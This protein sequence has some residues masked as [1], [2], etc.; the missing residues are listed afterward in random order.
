LITGSMACA[1]LLGGAIVAADGATESETYAGLP[2]AA[3]ARTIHI[4]QGFQV[5][6]VAAEPLVADPV[7]IAWDAA[8]RM[9]L[10]EMADYPTGG[11]AGRI[12]RLEDSDGDGFPDRAS[13]F[14]AGL[15]YPTSVLPLRGGILVAAAP[16]IL[17]LEDRDGDGVADERRVVLTGFGLGTTQLRVNGLIWGIDGRVYAANGRS[18]GQ[19]RNPSD[20][21]AAA[22]VISRR[23]LRFDPV[24]FRPEAIAGPSQFGHDFDA[25]GR[26][27]LSWNTIHVR[28][29]VLSPA[30]LERNP[31]LTRTETVAAISDH[32]DSARVYPLAPPPRTYN[33]EPTD[34]FN[35][36]C[37]LTV[38]CGG[39]FPTP[40]AG[41][42][43]VCEPLTG[44]VHRDELVAGDGPQRVARRGEH[45]REFLASTDPWFH[46]VFARSGPD[47]CLYVA[48]FYRE[49]VEHPEYV[50]REIRASVDYRRGSSHGRI[51]RV[52]PEGA[53]RQAVEDLSRLSSESLVDRLASPNG[54]VR[55]T[56]Q[57]LLLE[58]G[59]ASC[60]AR[61]EASAGGS[62]GTLARVE[63]LWTLHRL[64]RLRPELLDAALDPALDTVP[65]AGERVV[66]N[67]LRIAR[68]LPAEV[69]S[70][71]LFVARVE[72]LAGSPDAEVVRDAVLLLGDLR[73]DAA[74]GA[75]RALAS[76]AARTAP[77][78]ARKPAGDAW[79]LAAVLSGSSGRETALVREL[80]ALPS[81]GSP[82]GEACSAAAEA[83]RAAAELAGADRASA[84]TAEAEVLR[85]IVEILSRGDAAGAVTVGEGLATGLARS[86][87]AP[88]GVAE[89]NRLYEEAVRAATDARAQIGLR[90][91]SL[92]LLG[93]APWDSAQSAVQSALRPGE[94]LEL[95]LEAA[96]ALGNQ[97]ASDAGKLLMDV[98][99]AA[100][101]ALRGGILAALLRRPDGMERLADAI[102]AR[103]V[104][105]RDV[106]PGRRVALVRASAAPVAAR[107]TAAF[108]SGSGPSD[109]AQRS[110]VVESYLKELPASGDAATGAAVFAERCASC[111]RLGGEGHDVGPDLDGAGKKTREE[112][113]A[114]IL[115]PNRSTAA[116]FT[117]YVVTLRTGRV[118]TGIVRSETSSAVTLRGSG[119]VEE[120]VERAD[121]DTIASTGASLMPEGLEAVISPVSLADLLEC[122]R[123][124]K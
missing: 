65:A 117:A 67:A 105:P 82:A 78:A 5:E 55:E 29:E 84:A 87:R 90:R 40:Y 20:P 101:P 19:V 37:G 10:A 74:R 123:R 64:G 56:A 43:F 49:T 98:W 32:G 34:H 83:A 111:H 21:V 113:V 71:P 7:S 47:G 23:D 99:P 39:I 80:A 102:D 85:V 62:A 60:T 112:L 16:D 18:D 54:R 75:M 4:E 3:S 92:A 1:V 88:S 15:A 45:G 119:G 97:S 8:G 58:R 118:I 96:A 95:Q 103:S 116:G 115:D 25:W 77:G 2:P 24:T 17:F 104:N 12:R 38:E 44:L 110:R 108:G 9:W 114:S 76:A 106:D 28:Q 13:I 81:F 14:V 100:T 122:L 50:P 124:V 6:L 52:V 109:A 46:P 66:G 63:S 33:N 26:R 70:R 11:P 22:V 86:G 69:T 107:L 121:I 48:D 35:A 94:P 61:L 51:Y 36:S 57:R 68:E 72:K 120:G 73:G 30:D 59:D 41:S 42:I 27:F 31:K 93:R 91:R 89:W 79:L 53:A